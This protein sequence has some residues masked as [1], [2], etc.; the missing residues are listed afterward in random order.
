[1]M[2]VWIAG[3][4]EKGRMLELENRWD[5]PLDAALSIGHAA[6]GEILHFWFDGN[7]DRE[8]DA[9]VYW[10]VQ[11]RKYRKYEI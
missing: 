4:S 11:Y 6:D 1:M 3:D 2:K 10:D 7:A 8:P 5:N 9:C